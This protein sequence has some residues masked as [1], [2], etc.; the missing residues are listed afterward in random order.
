MAEL[1]DHGLVLQLDVGFF[2]QRRRNHHVLVGILQSDVFVEG[3]FDF[4]S[5]EVGAVV[6][7]HS[8]H[9]HRRCGVLRSARRG[10]RIGATLGEESRQ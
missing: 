4:L 2:A 6:F 9:D 10:H 7:G 5:D 3:D 8:L 1:H